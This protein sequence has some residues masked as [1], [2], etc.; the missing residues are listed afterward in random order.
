MLSIEL[1]ILEGK[2]G[3]EEIKGSG[4]S[5]CVSMLPSVT[6]EAALLPQVDRAGYVSHL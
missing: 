3:D 6:E 2:L 4:P 5:A 1:E